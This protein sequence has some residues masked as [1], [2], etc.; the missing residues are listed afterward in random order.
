MAPP[1]A[2]VAVPR[3][4]ER[5]RGKRLAARDRPVAGPEA[6][7]PVPAE[8]PRAAPPPL[9]APSASGR[10]GYAA[11]FADAQAL[12]SSGDTAK[13]AARYEEAAHLRPD[14]AL[15]HREL[16]KC[17]S[18]LGQRAR[19]QQEYR[20]YLELAPDATDAAFYRSILT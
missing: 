7:A 3:V 19:S 13:A 6:V 8:T 4:E 16:G 10:T 14:S 9:T 12:F 18:R 1:A 5:S 17:Y 15:V 2:A 20:R 11:V